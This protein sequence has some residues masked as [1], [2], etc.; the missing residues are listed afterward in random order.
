MTIADDEPG[1]RDDLALDADRG[2]AREPDELP[3]VR[4]VSSAPVASLRRTIGMEELPSFFDM[5]YPAIVGSLTRQGVP[6]AGPALGIYFGTPGETID[7]A[8][9][10]PIAA[11]ILPDGEV[12]EI[13]LP[14]GRVAEV[15]HHGSYG[16][17]GQTYQRLEDW[18]RAEGLVPGEVTWE[19]Y[20]TMPTPEADPRDMRTRISWLLADD[21]DEGR[22]GGDDRA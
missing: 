1:D 17:L 22:A 3:R 9:A 5:A 13:L 10:F 6:P 14:A 16:T 21:T 11:A 15:V 19:T 4:E 18:M 8:A 2:E 20:E 12:H 7:V